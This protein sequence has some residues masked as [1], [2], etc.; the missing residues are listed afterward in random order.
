MGNFFS[1]PNT[2]QISTPSQQGSFMDFVNQNQA[3]QQIPQQTPP[4][5]SQQ[6]SFMDFVNQGP[7]PQ[8]AAATFDDDTSYNADYNES[9]YSE[10]DD[11]GD[12]ETFMDFASHNQMGGG[13]RN[14][15][16]AALADLMATLKKVK[17]EGRK[18]NADFEALA[19]LV[20]SKQN[21]LKRIRI[22]NRPP[23][24]SDTRTEIL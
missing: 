17:I 19:A 20:Q 16:Q 18:A 23:R 6:G 8:I 15:E 3:P 1:A 2:Q 5:I 13:G 9:D 14:A 24:Q 22:L 7:Q 12:D 11:E 21:N 4:Q 10:G